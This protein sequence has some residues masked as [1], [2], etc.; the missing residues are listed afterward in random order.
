M[1]NI[2][3]SRGVRLSRYHGHRARRVNPVV[4]WRR[5]TRYDAAFSF[6]DRMR[7]CSRVS[8]DRFVLVALATAACALTGCDGKK[9]ASDRIVLKGRVTVDQSFLHGVTVVARCGS[10]ESRAA[11][12]DTGE[13][14]IEVPDSGCDRVVISW[15]KESFATTTRT[16][17]LPSPHREI[18]LNL[19]MAPMVELICGQADCSPEPVSEGTSVI[20]GAPAGEI[21]RGWVGGF[22]GQESLEAIPGEF[23][24]VDGRPLLL[25]A[26]TES[27]YRRQDGSA[28]TSLAAPFP[29]CVSVDSPSYDELQDLNPVVPPMTEGFIEFNTY[30]LDPVSGRWRAGEQGTVSAAGE[31]ADGRLAAVEYP[32]KVLGDIR[33]G[34]PPGI[35]IPGGVGED[36]QPVTITLGGA[37]L[38]TTQRAAGIVAMG[39][40]Q[41]AKS[42]VVV[43]L[44]DACGEPEDEATVEMRG[45]D[46]SF[47][48]WGPTGADGRVCLEAP[49]SEAQGESQT[50]DGVNGETFWVNLTLVGASAAGDVTAVALPTKSGNCGQPTSCL[51]VRVQADLESGQNCN[52]DAGV[53]LGGGD[54]PA[55]GA[56][57][58][59]DP[60]GP[61]RITG[62]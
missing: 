57:A 19:E 55:E 61:I 7:R 43:E 27:D 11:A 40:P 22:A 26:M 6:G 20:A 30:Q 46:R 21:A 37:W 13:Y 3:A 60:E 51:V 12:N 4:L 32:A 35:E 9:T 54:P 44:L 48:N 10:V 59:A 47:Y 25:L 53:S 34:V 23:F 28:L 49:R 14:A 36:G 31:G 5:P 24:D 2:Q 52:A 56:D 42:C 1:R 17:R 50:L 8:L 38:C 41:E 33:R 45:R 39:Y 29:I 16:L 15:Q 18:E 58:G 62:K